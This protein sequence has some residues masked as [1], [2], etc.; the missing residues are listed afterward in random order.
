MKST[1]STFEEIDLHVV[2]ILIFV[3]ILSILVLSFPWPAFTIAIFPQGRILTK[4]LVSHRNAHKSSLAYLF[5]NEA[6][7]VLSIAAYYF[8]SKK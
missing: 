6:I 4:A 3:S 1:V 8:I 7:V 2:Y 5:I